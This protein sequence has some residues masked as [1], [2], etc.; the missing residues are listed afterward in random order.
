MTDTLT[1]LRRTSLYDAHVALGARLVP[2]AGWEMPVQYPAGISIEHRAVRESCGVFDVSHMGEVVVR[3]PQAIEFVNYVTSNDASRLAVGQIQYTTL[4]TE[5]GTIVDDLLVYRFPDH[6]FLVPNAGNRDADLAH[7]RAHIGAFDAELTDVSDSYAL[8]AV[9]GPN[10]P[11]VLQRLTTAPLSE[12]KYY[13]FV[14]GEVA[15]VPTIISR[16]G[17]TGELGF[18]LYVPWDDARTVWDAVLAGGDVAPAGLGARDTLRLEA[19]MALYGHELN[20]NTTPLEAG[21]SWLVKLDKQAFLGKDVLIAQHTDGVDRKL[22]GFTF[23]ERAIPR[24]GMPVWYGDVQVGEV[25][26]GTMSPTLGIPIGT[27]YVPAAAAVE[28]SVFYVDI[29]GRKVAAR[30]VPMPFYKRSGKA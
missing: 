8:I 17:Y 20:I 19:G 26:S 13:R 25:C 22:V 11:E 3:G 1:T 9:Q 16:T 23:D 28:G 5:R 21:L 14:E 30:A 10:A 4:L 18:E 12:M 7:L 6:L 27:C 15:G 29:R 2:F 24:H